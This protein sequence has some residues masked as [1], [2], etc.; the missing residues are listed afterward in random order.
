MCEAQA[1]AFPNEEGMYRR[2][3]PSFLTNIDNVYICAQDNTTHLKKMR[4]FT[5]SCILFHMK[6]LVGVKA[7]IVNQNKVLLLREASYDEGINEG[8]WDV[9]GGR[10]NPEESIIEGLR[11]E[12]REE[13]GLEIDLGEVLGVF[14]TFSMIKG[15]ECHIVRIFYKAEAKSTEI[16]LSD[17]HDAYAWVT[18]EDLKD[19]ELVSSLPELIQKSLSI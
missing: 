15:E 1:T 13:S 6:L 14:D 12:V 11:R 4:G 19:K 2:Y 8:K 9:P 3:T 10:I 18:L 5:E 16:V 7:L 17:D